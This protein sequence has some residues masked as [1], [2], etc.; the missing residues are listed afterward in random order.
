MTNDFI[1]FI[2]ERGFINQTTN[3]EE[4]DVLSRANAVHP[5]IGFDL[6][7]D[8]LHVG[9]LIQLMVLRW[10]EAANIRST[11]LLGDFTTRVGDPTGRK[12]ARPVL[13]PEQ[14]MKN[15][16][17]IRNT[18][19][20]QRAGLSN[21]LD[22]SKH[23]VVS[24]DEWLL[25][26]GLLEYLTEYAPLFSVNRM[27]AMDSVKDRIADNGHMSVLE[28]NYSLFQA[29]DFLHLNDGGCN[30]Q[31]GG[32]DQWSNI[33]SGIDLIRRKNNRTAYGL[34]TP[35]MTNAAGE[36]MG[37]TAGGALWL[38]AA[39]TPVDDFWQF[40]RN[41]E[42]AK[43]SQ[44]LGLF[45]E[46]PMDEVTR[47]RAIGGQEINEVKKILATEA[48]RIVHG[49]NAAKKA[50]ATAQALFESADPASQEPILV[51]YPEQPLYELVAKVMNV[52]KSEAR[53]LCDQNAVKIDNQVMET[54]F[55]VARIVREGVPFMLSVGKKHRF[56]MEVGESGI[57]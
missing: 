32:S 12:D 30:L 16:E 48:T 36:K 11:V 37:K 23:D 15:H 35:L 21:I 47:L 2:H 49:D 9:S 26:M 45:T 44:F 19:F 53:R 43:V 4:L 46:L 25:N 56:R 17:G 22:I 7:A 20:G 14:A 3:R 10:A 1:S 54:N 57:Q 5:Y 13:S 38:S 27:L 55:I 28:F 39:K 40:W 31:I 50:A 42:D 8:S 34:T 24:N 51:L 6:T 29:I 33:L 18:I 52:S 41:V